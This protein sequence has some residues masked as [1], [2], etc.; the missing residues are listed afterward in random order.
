MKFEQLGRAV[1]DHLKQHPEASP[2]EQIPAL[3]DFLHS[4][5]GLEK[6][7]LTLHEWQMIADAMI[8]EHS[9]GLQAELEALLVQQER[10]ARQIERKRETLQET[11]H[12]VFNALESFTADE[13]AAVLASLHQTRLHSIDLVDMLEELM[14]SAII[15]TL[16]KNHD[17]E[18]TVEE[19]SREITYE[20]LGEG[21]LQRERI[22]LVAGSI[23]GSAVNVA[24]ASPVHA[25]QI[26][27]GTLK[28]IRSGLIKA[29]RRLKKQ[30][31]FVPEELRLTETM[32]TELLRTDAL[33]T[34]IVQDHALRCSAE[35]RTLL[36]RLS[37][38][39]RYDLEELV[40]VSR[41]AVEVMREQ[42]SH[43]FSRSQVLNSKTAAEAKRMGISA[44]RSAKTTLHGALQ[45]AKDKI[46]KKS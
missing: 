36:E 2:Q 4:E 32:Q 26:L 15:T 12:A 41:E 37:K 39:M 45:N 30:L 21:P 23:L 43:V 18:E 9:D 33:F 17:I 29:I 34:Q 25:H 46:D 27:R 38:E 7:N 6:Q 35:S 24:E 40:E 31:L 16:E 44:W 28:G 14:E 22:R 3:F 19:I 42:L 11:K 5:F 10:L 1:R 13:D 8:N 20:T